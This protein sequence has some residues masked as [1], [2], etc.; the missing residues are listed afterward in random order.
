LDCL[1]FKFGREPSSLCH[2]TPPW[3]RS[4]PPFEV[5]VKPGLA[6]PDPF[7]V[8]DTWAAEQ[9]ETLRA[10]IKTLVGL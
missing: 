5:S 1:S 8:L 3:G 2:L 7:L 9:R 4:V 10:E 6:H